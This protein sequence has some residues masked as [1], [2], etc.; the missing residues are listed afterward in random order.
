MSLE[1]EYTETLTVCHCWC[2]IA[3]AIPQNLYRVAHESPKDI[4]CPL[5]HVFVWGDTFEEKLKKEKQRHEATRHLL[6]AEERSHSATR[7]QITKLKKR[8]HAGVCPCCNRSFQ[9]VARH[10]KTKHPDYVAPTA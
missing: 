7:G 2:G 6:A 8:V 1:M 3:L 9:N 5:G 10:M 4:Y